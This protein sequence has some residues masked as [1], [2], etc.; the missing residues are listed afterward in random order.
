MS[1]ENYFPHMTIGKGGTVG[2]LD[3]PLSFAVTRLALGHAS[4]FGTCSA[5]LAEANSGVIASH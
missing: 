3:S 1:G 2:P 5:I 4:G